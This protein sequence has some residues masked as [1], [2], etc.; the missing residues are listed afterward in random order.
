LITWA[1]RTTSSD[2]ADRH[3]AGIHR[4]V[5]MFNPPGGCFQR[6]HFS[7]PQTPHLTIRKLL[8]QK[9]LSSA[10]ITRNLPVPATPSTSLLSAVVLSSLA[11]APTL[12]QPTT[13][14]RSLTARAPVTV[15]CLV[16]CARARATRAST[17]RNATCPEIQP[18]LLRG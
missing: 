18:S 11:T 13:G 3:E 14:P 7:R 12:L 2:D 10:H 9:C 16:V 17:R 8:L 15:A 6:S 1:H 5:F 4:S